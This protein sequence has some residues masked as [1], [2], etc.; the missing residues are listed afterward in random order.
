MFHA[1][2]LTYFNVNISPANFPGRPSQ[3][4]TATLLIYV[5]YHNLTFICISEVPLG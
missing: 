1:N 5:K 3:S 2:M 4:G